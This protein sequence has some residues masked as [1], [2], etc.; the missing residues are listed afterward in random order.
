V[1]WSL[2]SE[3]G[4]KKKKNTKAKQRDRKISPYKH[5]KAKTDSTSMKRN[6][7]PV[8]ANDVRLISIWD[9]PLFLNAVSFLLSKQ[10][11][12]SKTLSLCSTCPRFLCGS[13]PVPN[14]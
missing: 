13:G 8:A 7:I 6:S 14:P 3:G 1:A 2:I 9:P 10:L 11:S 4:K 5:L 12:L